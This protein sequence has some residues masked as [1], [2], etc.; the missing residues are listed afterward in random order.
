MRWRT[1]A[2]LALI[3]AACLQAAAA[4]WALMGAQDMRARA[5]NAWEQADAH[6]LAAL[7]DVGEVTART[8]A[9]DVARTLR[10][11]EDWRVV[12]MEA[13][14]AI[15]H[16]VTRQMTRFCMGQGCEI[17]APDADPSGEDLPRDL[18]LR[19]QPVRISFRMMEILP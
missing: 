7:S 11:D 13:S 16:C 2:G 14:N 18:L 3:L 10:P 15:T 4:A 6:C 5:V 17:R 1:L 8:G 9:V 19:S 12:L